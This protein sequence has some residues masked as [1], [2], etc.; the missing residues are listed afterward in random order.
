VDWKRLFGGFNEEAWAEHYEQAMGLAQRGRL[1][2]A[3]E[4]MKKAVELASRPGGEEQL[5]ESCV[6]L[7]NIQLELGRFEL[8][9]PAYTQAVD[10][11]RHFRGPQDRTVA[12]A[13]TFLANCHEEQGRYE[14]AAQRYGEAIEILE[15]QPPGDGPSQLLT[16]TRSNLATVLANLGKGAEALA[17][18]QRVVDT[19]RQ[20]G[21][22]AELSVALWSRSTIASRQG[23]HD[24]AIRAAREALELAERWNG[25]DSVPVFQAVHQYGNILVKAG[26]AA[27]VIPVFEE[28][29]QRLRASGAQEPILE[30]TWME[31]LADALLEAG[32]FEASERWYQRCLDAFTQLHGSLHQNLL[33]GVEGY[34]ELLRRQGREADLR[35]QQRRL[36]EIQAALPPELV[37]RNSRK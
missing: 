14:L 29:L 3:V 6:G 26:R 10:V 27:E 32:R 5:V 2:L 28:G 19:E 21:N 25:P 18:N 36:K 4:S 31:S 12:G 30:A 24:E 8:A 7:G 17:L 1:P 9:E 23:L 15:S 33:S 13:L 20:N 34:C 11:A 35:E 37:R 22:P 16:N